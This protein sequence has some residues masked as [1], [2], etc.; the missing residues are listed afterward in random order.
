MLGIEAWASFGLIRIQLL[1]CNVIRFPISLDVGARLT[2]TNMLL[3]GT[4]WM[5]LLAADCS[6]VLA[7]FSGPLLLAT[8]MIL[9]PYNILIPGRWNSWLRR[10]CLVCRSLW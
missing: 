3:V 7:I 9:R 4:G 1:L 2:V 10:T 5:S 8:L 6:I